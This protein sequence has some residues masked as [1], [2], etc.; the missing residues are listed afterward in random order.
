MPRK[1]DPVL[2]DLPPDVV[3]ADLDW[4]TAGPSHTYEEQKALGLDYDTG[5]TGELR[6]YFTAKFGWCL[7]T[8]PIS[9]GQGNSPPRTYGIKLSGEIVTMGKGPHVLKDV[10]VLIRPANYERLKKYVDLWKKGMADA[11][12]IR[13]RIS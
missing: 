5:W 13:D 7:C 10:T 8:L 4:K 3:A 2:S 1:P 11:G 9:K 12:G 6:F